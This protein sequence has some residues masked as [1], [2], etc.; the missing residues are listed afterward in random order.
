MHHPKDC[1]ISLDDWTLRLLHVTIFLEFH[2]S[3]F[4]SPVLGLVGALKMTCF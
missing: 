4:S 1:P 3:E 2:S